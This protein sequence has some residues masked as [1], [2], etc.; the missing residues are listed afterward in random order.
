ME[1]FMDYLAWVLVVLS[2]A[3]NI[4]VNR[5]QVIG[6]WLW[7][8]A[9]VGWIAFNLYKGINPQAFLFTVYLGICA[10]G[11]IKWTKEAKEQKKL[12]AKID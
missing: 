7:A 12:N 9:N 11:I 2:L 1:N 6:Q 4:F 3:G 5:K 8:I 10:W